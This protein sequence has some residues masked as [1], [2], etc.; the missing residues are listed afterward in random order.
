MPR[1]VIRVPV[2]SLKDGDSPRAGGIDPDHVQALAES[3]RGFDPILV[4]RATR[5][6][7]DGMHRLQAA[8]LRG[9][10][11]IAVRYLDGPADE[12]FI[13][14]VRANITHGLPLTLK[15]RKLAAERIL[16][17]H[18]AWSDRAIARITDL[19]PKTVGAARRRSTE[20]IP[21]PNTR[22]GQ[23]GRARPADPAL[24]REIAR[25][26]LA[27]RP[28]VPLR[29]VAAFAG[30]SVSTAHDVSRRM[31]GG[32][33]PESAGVSRTDKRG[34]RSTVAGVRRDPDVGRNRV[35][36][37]RSLASDPSLRLT[38][39]GRALVR[40]LSA[41]ALDIEAGER[42]LAAVPPHCAVT[43]ADLAQCYAEEWERFARELSRPQEQEDAQRAG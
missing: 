21:Q 38:E 6:V 25:T 15:D 8:V 27:E 43:V 12:V 30:I 20:D 17:M 4:H 36:A 40:W 23:D 22:V 34:T 18:P 11:D 33:Q 10:R 41:R 5:Q 37:L 31:R 3:P 39:P 19:S 29:E 16:R 35:T 7:I 14:A 32:E 9:E 26:L 42:L 24:R 13:Q 2:S 1:P 28:G